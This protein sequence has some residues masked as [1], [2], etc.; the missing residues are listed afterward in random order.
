MMSSGFDDRDVEDALRKVPVKIGQGK[1][2][3]SLKDAMPAMVVSDLVDICKEYARRN[4]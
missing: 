4:C 3:V 1:V 2:T